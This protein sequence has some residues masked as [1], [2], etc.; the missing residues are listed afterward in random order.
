MPFDLRVTF[1]GMCLFV[2][3]AGTGLTHVLLLAPDQCIPMS[4]PSSATQGMSRHYPR[5]FYSSSLDGA[6]ESLPASPFRCVSIDDKL[7]DFSGLP[8]DSS[9]LTLP[10]AIVRLDV[11]PLERKW[12]GQN[13]TDPISARVVLPST[14]YMEYSHC[15]SC[16][17]GQTPVPAATQVTWVL[18]DVDAGALEWRLDGLRKDGGVPLPTLN[19]RMTHGTIE[20]RIKNA[21]HDCTVPEETIG[22]PPADGRVPHFAAYYTPF[23]VSGQ[24]LMIDNPQPSA[25]GTVKINSDSYTCMTAQG[26]LT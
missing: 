3:D 17:L 7:L 13:P 2:Q 16:H 15:V 18:R 9:G 22:L 11:P 5:V 12:I 26:P 10:D 6:P 20:L 25:R 21:V 4:M 24:D 23:G 19:P 1:S 14:G 8:H